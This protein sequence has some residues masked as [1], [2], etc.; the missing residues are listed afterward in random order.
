MVDE[1]PKNLAI[2]QDEAPD[3][4]NLIR[5]TAI[6]QQQATISLIAA[7]Q[8]IVDHQTQL[9]PRLE[10]QDANHEQLGRMIHEVRQIATEQRR[11][12]SQ[13]NTQ[14]REWLDAR[15][16]TSRI[17][18]PPFR[19]TPR[20]RTPNLDLAGASVWRGGVLSRIWRNRLLGAGAGAAIAAEGLWVIAVSVAI[21]CLIFR[22]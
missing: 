14:C 15:R 13:L 21:I 16:R 18:R 8:I 9:A 19:A 12:T 10:R 2:E 6:A 11:V 20:R 1:D 22:R 7:Q 3:I 17:Q 5:T 4:N